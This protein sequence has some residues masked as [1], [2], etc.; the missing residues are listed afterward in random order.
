[1]AKGKSMF[2]KIMKKT[3]K[4]TTLSHDLLHNQFVLYFIF[5]IAVANLFHFVFANDI[6]S[7]GTFIAT[8]LL[9]SFFS[10]NM[11][12]IMVISIVVTHVIRIGNGNTR[13]GFKSKKSDE[14]DKEVDEDL[15]QEITDIIEEDIEKKEEEEEEDQ[16]KEKEVEEKD[17]E[18]F[19][20]WNTNR[21]NITANKN[22]INTN[23]N[24][25]TANKNDINTNRNNITANK[26]DIQANKDAIAGLTQKNTYN[27]KVNPVK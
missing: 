20:P 2:S 25:I 8:G 26:N 9:T 22:D 24:N 16:E 21:N 6:M 13:D 11:I 3:G 17:Q 23:R 18:P 19:R 14:D 1:M 15:V 10:K 12:V 5:I 27:I 7:V 4:M